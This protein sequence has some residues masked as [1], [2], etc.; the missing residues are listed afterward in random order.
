MNIP[1]PP[2]PV[3]D[4]GGATFFGFMG[5]SLALVLASNHSYSQISVLLTG[6]LKQ[7][8]ESAVFLFGDQLLL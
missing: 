5:V 6:L 4:N 3:P 7:V 8:Q 2:V 1:V